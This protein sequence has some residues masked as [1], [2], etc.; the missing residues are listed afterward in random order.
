MNLTNILR[1]TLMNKYF[2]FSIFVIVITAS[3]I[4]MHNKLECDNDDIKA[5]PNMKKKCVNNYDFV[6]IL[7]IIMLSVSS[8]I[9]AGILFVSIKDNID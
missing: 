3:S 4:S 5:C 7:N 2:I 8:I 1:S 9:V 6:N